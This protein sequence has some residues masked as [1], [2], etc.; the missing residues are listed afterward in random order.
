PRLKWSFTASRPDRISTK[1]MLMTMPVASAPKSGIPAASSIST[2]PI[3]HCCVQLIDVCVP[4]IR[5]GHHHG[6]RHLV[7]DALS[8]PLDKL[9]W[10]C[11]EGRHAAHAAHGL[12]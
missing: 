11:Q 10:G 2:S 1:T 8:V 7:G 12:D 9:I 6:H 3:S 4:H 5:Q